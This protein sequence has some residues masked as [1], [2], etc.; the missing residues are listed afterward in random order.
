MKIIER[1]YI[2]PKDVMYNTSIGIV[3][4]DCLGR[5]Y[6]NGWYEKYEKYRVTDEEILKKVTNSNMLSNE[7]FTKILTERNNQLT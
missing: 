4:Y 3:K 2:F 7:I 6:K 1:M 5:L